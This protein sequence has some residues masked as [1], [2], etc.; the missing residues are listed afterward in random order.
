MVYFA[1]APGVEL[2]LKPLAAST[3]EEEPQNVAPRGS[4]G[5]FIATVIF[6][7]GFAALAS[8]RVT[9]VTSHDLLPQGA[10]AAASR[11]ADGAAGCRRPRGGGRGELREVCAAG[12]ASCGRRMARPAAEAARRMARP[13]AACAGGARGSCRG[14]GLRAPRRPETTMEAGAASSGGRGAGNQEVTVSP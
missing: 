2:P 9:P 5:C 14:G 10:A 3:R 8:S 7:P 12:E 4:S 13:A 1:L 11:V 6:A